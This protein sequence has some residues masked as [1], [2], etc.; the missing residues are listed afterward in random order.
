MGILETLDTNARIVAGA[1]GVHVTTPRLAGEVAR[2]GGVG[3]ISETA[4]GTVLARQLQDGDSSGEIRRALAAFPN[5]K[6]V[7]TVALDRYYRE[8]GR[9]ADEPYALVPQPR[10]KQDSVAEAMHVIGVFTQAWLAQEY[11]GGS[12][13]IAANRLGKIPRLAAAGIGGSL[14]AGVPIIVQGAGM[15][16]EVPSILRNLVADGRTRYDAGVVGQRKGE[17]WEFDIT[18]Y[19]ADSRTLAM[20]EFWPIISHPDM[21]DEL[22]KHGDI[23]AVVVESRVAAGHNSPSKGPEPSIDAYLEKNVPI[24]LAGGE[25]SRGLREAQRLG[26]AAIQVGSLFALTRESGAAP[27]LKGRAISMARMSKL[28]VRQDALASP[29][30]FPFQ[31]ADI[32]DTLSDSRVLADRVPHKICDLGYLTTAYTTADGRIGYRCLAEPEEKYVQKIAN[33]RLAQALGKRMCLCNALLATADMPQ[34]QKDG[35]VEPPVLT[36]GETVREDVQA[37]IAEYGLPLTVEKV[38]HYLTQ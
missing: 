10:G 17:Q 2:L 34:V 7:E 29:T 8:N 23:D 37:V 33:P 35:Y 12:G 21:I 27:A 15:P 36:L 28:E 16:T 18:T 6:M 14:L 32:P 3:T 24:I 1:A 20:P 26:A 4:A 9:R 31:I 11:S 13:A 38:F 25:A 19:N 30:G 5:Q 22:R